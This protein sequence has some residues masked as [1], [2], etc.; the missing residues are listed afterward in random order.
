[1]FSAPI[2]FSKMHRFATV[3]RQFAA[4]FGEAAKGLLIRLAFELHGS[5]FVAEVFVV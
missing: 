1:M 2:P 5:P 3:A 4:E